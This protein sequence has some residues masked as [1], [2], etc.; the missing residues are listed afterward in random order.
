MSSGEQKKWKKE[1]AEEYDLYIRQYY[2][3]RDTFSGKYQLWAKY[4]NP[5]AFKGDVSKTVTAK[6]GN[7]LT[8]TEAAI[9]RGSKRSHR[10]GGLLGGMWRYRT[11]KMWQ[12]Y[13]NRNYVGTPYYWQFLSSYVPLGMRSTWDALGL[14]MPGKLGRG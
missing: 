8:A 11:V 9:R 4:Y 6:E 7:I 3:Y 13:Y 5:D 14:L 10:H 1:H 2:S 12:T